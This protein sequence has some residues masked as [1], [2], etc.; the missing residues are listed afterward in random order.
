MDPGTDHGTPGQYP[1]TTLNE[2]SSVIQ[3]PASRHVTAT[4]ARDAQILTQT[5]TRTYSDLEKDDLS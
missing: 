4:G 3:E 5:Y 2:L 1:V